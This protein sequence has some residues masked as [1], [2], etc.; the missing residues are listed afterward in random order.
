[1][2]IFGTKEF[3]YEQGGLP[4]GMGGPPKPPESDEDLLWKKVKEYHKIDTL[5]QQMQMQGSADS[6]ILDTIYKKFYPEF[7]YFAKEI[8]IDKAKPKPEQP[9]GGMPGMGGPP[10]QGAGEDGGQMGAGPG[11]P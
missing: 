6:V 9:P 2:N 10:S 8:L 4:P 7:V 3:L 11:G 1:M 5:I